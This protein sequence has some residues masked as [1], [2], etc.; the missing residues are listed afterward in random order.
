MGMDVY[1]K[2]PVSERGTYFRNN[3]WWWH[4]LWRYCEE[5]APDLIPDD[6]LGHSNDGWGLD[7]EEAVALADR[8]AAALASGATGRY[9]KR[10]QE[11]LDA[12]P[13]EPCTICDA[14]GHRAEPPQ[15]GPG[16]RLC[17]G[18]N[19]TGKVPN[20]A[21]HYPFSAENVREFEAFLRDSGGFSI[22]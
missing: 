16:P 11:T 4:P 14:S 6:N 13:L 12:L 15:T 10:Y 1:G 20:F 22:C 19:G 2:A 5:M 21:T 8:L 7:G 9:A 17:N 18:C 3:V